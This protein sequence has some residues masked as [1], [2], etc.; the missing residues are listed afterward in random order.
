MKAVTKE[1]GGFIALKLSD[2]NFEVPTTSLKER[3][4]ETR[5]HTY[6]A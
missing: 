6:M 3:W 4:K 5:K 2:H 1:D